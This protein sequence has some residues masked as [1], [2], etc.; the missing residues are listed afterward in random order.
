MN[1]N[2][3]LMCAMNHHQLIF[4][5]T[6]EHTDEERLHHLS[7]HSKT[8]LVKA[9]LSVLWISTWDRAGNLLG[10]GEKPIQGLSIRA[11]ASNLAALFWEHIGTIPL[12][13]QDQT[14]LHPLL[15]ALLQAC[16]K[17]DPPPNCQKALTPKFLWHLFAFSSDHHLWA[18][19][20]EHAVDLIIGSFFYAMRACEYVLPL[21]PGKTK[22]LCLHHVT[23][24]DAEKQSIPFTDPL[25]VNKVMYT[26]I[27]FEDQKNSNKMDQQSQ[28]RT[29]DPIL[30]PCCRLAR[31]V[32]RIIATVPHW[33]MDTLLCTIH[34]NNTTSYLNST[35][36][37][38][39]LQ[40]TSKQL[41]G[42]WEFGFAPHEI[43]NKS[44]QSGA[45]MALFI[46]DH[47]TAKIMIL[48]HW[49]SDA[50]LDYIHP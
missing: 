29:Q 30:C 31:A 7:P 37:Q 42:N 39:L 4:W 26:T 12:H 21:K 1:N 17:V 2:H 47:S 8:L 3:S 46:Q 13:I 38:N 10:E 19:A 34:L 23:F 28:K 25:L 5:N 20:Y 43:G 11:A 50:F 18:N 48:G 41:G 45:A 40:H 24:C 36:I 9:F 22:T 16:D 27:T 32:Q 44:L 35:F 15:K 49:S 33:T 14:K 6:H